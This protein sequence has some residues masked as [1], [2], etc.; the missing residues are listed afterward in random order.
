MMDI[1]NIADSIK[2]LFDTTLRK[3]ANIIPGIIMLCS[4][5]KR[6]GLSALISFSNI[7]QELAKQGIPTEPLPDGTPNI[8]NK[9]IYSVVKETYRAIKEDSNVQII[10]KEQV[11]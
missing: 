1:K 11:A 3:P 9:L 10:V 4:L 2:K 6:P 8:M 5:A 7:V